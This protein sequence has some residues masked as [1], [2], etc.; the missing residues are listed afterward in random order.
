[1]FKNKRQNEIFTILLKE[2]EVKTK[3]LCQKFGVSDMTIRR[4]L[5]HL[6]NMQGV[7][8]THGGA[9]YSRSFADKKFG[10]EQIAMSDAKERIAVKALSFVEPNQRL[11]ID[12]GT[13]TMYVAKSFPMESHNIVLSNNLRIVNEVSTRPNVSVIIIGG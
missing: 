4:D 5:D 2:G 12:S 6:L 1:M 7:V 11:F 10:A 9:L 13:T 8:R 3:E